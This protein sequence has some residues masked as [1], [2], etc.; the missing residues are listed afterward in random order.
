M[1]SLS[2]LPD[3]VLGG[4]VLRRHLAPRGTLV[5]ARECRRVCRR[6]H[7][8]LEP[9]FWR[10]VSADP[11]SLASI[12]RVR[13]PSGG[14]GGG[15]G[16]G[17]GGDSKAAEA[18]WAA[19]IVELHVW[20]DSDD[21]YKMSSVEAVEVWEPALVSLLPA[22]TNL[23][24]L[25]F[26]VLVNAIVPL[27]VRHCRRLTSFDIQ[28]WQPY[29]HYLHCQLI[30]N[31]ASRLTGS[32]MNLKK[33]LLVVF[34]GL[35]SF[36]RNQSLQGTIADM[37]SLTC[38]YL[39]S[40]QQL[41]VVGAAE[42]FPQLRRL[43]IHPTEFESTL[44]GFFDEVAA[45]LSAL[46]PLNL[47][48]LYLHVFGTE[49]VLQSVVRHTPRV[50][51]VQLFLVDE[52][53]NSAVARSLS[54]ACPRIEYLHADGT[55]IASEPGYFPNLKH[56]RVAGRSEPVSWRDLGATRPHLRSLIL[57]RSVSLDDL[58]VI[59]ASLPSLA[60]VGHIELKESYSS[61]SDGVRVFERLACF[62]LALPCLRWIRIR[63]YSES[64]ADKF[65]LPWLSF[66]DRV[67]A[68]PPLVVQTTARVSRAVW[69]AAVRA[70]VD[71]WPPSDWTWPAVEFDA[72]P[73]D[74]ITG[75]MC[76]HC[77]YKCGID[78]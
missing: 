63:F 17:G 75:R 74:G 14:G 19:L 23:K 31:E 2:G 20:I 22:A 73:L 9:A 58:D 6:W 61:E 77:T 48:V 12:V 18:R 5:H 67:A 42:K 35:T 25:H 28:G 32:K 70:G 24:V 21:Y 7:D 27:V 60:C 45:M 36:P 50:R 37:E 64:A 26:P 53:D 49:K 71:F 1:A 62:V 16:D 15:D 11:A 39:S 57:S 56:L 29:L 43:T 69:R 44:E 40:F 65:D 47:P 41:F 4:E 68:A 52:Y 3:F 8:L 34:P 30:N 13:M 54:A 38:Y 10:F 59:A 46:P 51:S 72:W 55:A 33:S 76:H 78:D 66:L